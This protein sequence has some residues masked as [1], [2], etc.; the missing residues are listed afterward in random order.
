VKVPF[1]WKGTDWFMIG[2]SRQFPVGDVRLPDE[3]EIWRYLKHV[4]PWPSRVGPMRRCA[5]DDR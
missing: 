4:R 1:T 2:W 5:S 3:L